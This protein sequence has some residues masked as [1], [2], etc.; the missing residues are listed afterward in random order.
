[1]LAP[2]QSAQSRES[3]RDRGDRGAA[4]TALSRGG[5]EPASRAPGGPAGERASGRTSSGCG[6]GA[7][8]SGRSRTAWPDRGGS[9]LGGSRSRGRQPVDDRGSPRNDGRTDRGAQRAEVGP[10]ESRPA[11]EAPVAAQANTATYSP[12]IQRTSRGSCHAQDAFTA[13]GAGRRG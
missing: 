6:E 4:S 1:R 10:V 7:D 13:H 9:G 12:L 8:R 2:H 11:A 3:T 5:V